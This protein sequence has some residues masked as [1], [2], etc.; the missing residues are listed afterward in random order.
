[1]KENIKK[2]GFMVHK[3]DYSVTRNEKILKKFFELA[4]LRRVH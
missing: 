1:M 4:G 3:D 2:K